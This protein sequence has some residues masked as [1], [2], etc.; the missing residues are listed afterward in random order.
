MTRKAASILAAGLVA[1]ALLGMGASAGHA[2]TL[3][4]GVQDVVKLAQAG[5]SDEIILTQI[6]NNAA[7]Y[8]LTADQIILLKTQGVSQPVINAL[9]TG[10][11][12]AM[13]AA[14]P[15][16]PPPPLPAPAPA[17]AVTVPTPAVPAAS[18]EVFKPNWRPTE[19]GLKCRVMACAGSRRWW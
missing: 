13:P 7:S 16:S 19:I 10:G 2:Q 8:N 12:S 5:I 15:S 18:L 4:P 1:A 6:K 3:P 11:A 14:A 9:L 17:P